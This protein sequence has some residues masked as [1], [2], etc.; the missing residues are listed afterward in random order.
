MCIVWYCLYLL[1]ISG[2]REHQA[3]CCVVLEGLGLVTT[4]RYTKAYSLQCLTAQ[5]SAPNRDSVAM[6]TVCFHG[7]YKEFPLQSLLF[8][9][10]ISCI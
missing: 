3:L 8:K 4:Q 6:V 5:L 9:L 1:C 2:D 10:C 7:E